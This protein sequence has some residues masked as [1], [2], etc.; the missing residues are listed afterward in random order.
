VTNLSLA[1]VKSVA[2]E[3]AIKTQDCA[4]ICDGMCAGVHAVKASQAPT[5]NWTKHWIV[6]TALD[7][8]F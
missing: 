8:D 5:V 7:R 2:V 1:Y 6:V 3:H 4:S